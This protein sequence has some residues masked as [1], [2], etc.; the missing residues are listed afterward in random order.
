MRKYFCS[1][2]KRRAQTSRCRLAVWRQ[3]P[4]LL[5]ASSTLVTCSKK[6]NV[7]TGR[8][9]FWE[10]KCLLTR[11]EGGAVLREQNALPYGGWITVNLTAKAAINNCRAGRAAK[12]ETLVTCSNA[13]IQT[14]QAVWEREVVL[15]YGFVLRF[16]EK[17]IIIITIF[18]K[19]GLR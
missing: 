9:S 2:K 11:V 8:F 5:P 18:D 16:L 15:R 12:G 3:L 10:I 17:C 13:T 7:P 4:K 1:A 6:T 19:Q 14:L